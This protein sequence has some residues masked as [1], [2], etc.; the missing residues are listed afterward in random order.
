MADER[1]STNGI[2]KLRN[3]PKPLVAVNEIA[4]PGAPML[5]P[6]IELALAIGALGQARGCL[7]ALAPGVHE[8]QTG[9]VIDL[10]SLGTKAQAKID[11]LEVEEEPFVEAA[12][13]LER[14]TPHQE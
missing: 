9:V 13:L 4:N 10:A 12:H 11:V 5:L 6:I 14:I 2:A 8:R 7:G 1:L 3:A